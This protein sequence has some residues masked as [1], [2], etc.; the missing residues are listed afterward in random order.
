MEGLKEKE[1][2]SNFIKIKEHFYKVNKTHYFKERLFY[3]GD[4]VRVDTVTISMLKN[5]IEALRAVMKKPKE[6]IF[7]RWGNREDYNEKSL[8]KILK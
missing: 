8:E 1:L 3:K 2:S 7:Y 5:S 6:V 4:K